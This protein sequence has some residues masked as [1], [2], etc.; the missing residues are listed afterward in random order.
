MKKHLKSSVA[1]LLLF[2]AVTARFS[3]AGDIAVPDGWRTPA[4]AEVEEEWRDYSPNRYLE[5]KADFNG[6]G[7]IDAARILVRPDGSEMALFAF[8]CGKD[9]SCKEHLLASVKGAKAS[10]RMGIDRVHKGLYKTACGKVYREC[11]ENETPEVEIKN[12]SIDLFDFTG[13]NSYFYWDEG[14]KAFE[15]VWM[16][17]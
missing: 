9:G 2:I 15:R 12:D 1:L 8:I 6:D 10:R 4:G 7:A 3:F 5:V 14:K 13:G 16:S 11:K 17:D